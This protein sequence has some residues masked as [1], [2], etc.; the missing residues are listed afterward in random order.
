MSGRRI[1]AVGALVIGF[2]TL[3]LAVI[4]VVQEFPQGLMVLGL[5][6]LRRLVGW[7]GADPARCGAGRRPLRGGRGFDRGD[8]AGRQRARGGD[9]ADRGGLAGHRRLCGSRSEQAPG[10]LVG[11]PRPSTRS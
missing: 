2:A 10:P 9:R 11:S 8:P 1:A 3:V 4:L 5:V 7:Y 6:G